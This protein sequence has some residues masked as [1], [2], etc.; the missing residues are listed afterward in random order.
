VGTG[1]GALMHFLGQVFGWLTT[2]THWFGG[3]GLVHEL[4]QHLQVSAASLAVAIA[5]ALPIALVLG[6]YRRGGVIAVNVANAGRALPT[7]ALLV[8][9]VTVFGISS[10]RPLAWTGS[11]ATFLA[12]LLLG[13]PPILTNAYVGMLEVDRDLVDAARG[14]GMRGFQV[15]LGVELPVALP[16]VMAGVRTAALGVVATA[17]LASWTGYDTLGTPINVGIAV[18]DNV[19]VFAGALLVA[20]LALVVEVGLAGVQRLLVSPGLRVADR[21][22]VGQGRTGWGRAR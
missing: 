5:V 17:T 15:L 14:V 18:R 10:P 22:R 6:H 7:Y 13:I 1:S 8:L 12:L 21:E 11:A 2:R 16:L 9:A 19:A 4:R 20:V 3:D